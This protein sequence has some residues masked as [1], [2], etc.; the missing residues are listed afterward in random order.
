MDKSTQV[1][2]SDEHTE[3]GRRGIHPKADQINRITS[4]VCVSAIGMM[5][6]MLVVDLTV[7]ISSLGPLA[8]TLIVSAMAAGGVWVKFLFGYWIQLFQMRLAD[9]PF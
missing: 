4:T 2:P 8:V 1:R 3:T 6:A 5:I 7:G 9:K